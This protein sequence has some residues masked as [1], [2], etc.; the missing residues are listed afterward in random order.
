MEIYRQRD[1]EPYVNRVGGVDLY[2]ALIKN[3]ARSCV[4]VKERTGVI[5]ALEELRP[6]DCIIVFMGAGDIDEI[7]RR[8]AVAFTEGK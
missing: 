7:A 3:G 2:N 4:F 5:P 6:R 8:Y 1:S